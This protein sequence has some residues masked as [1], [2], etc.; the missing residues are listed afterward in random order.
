MSVLAGPISTLKKV[1]DNAP[2]RAL[3][4][5]L[6]I[7]FNSNNNIIPLH[8]QTA[9]GIAKRGGLLN[10]YVSNNSRLLLLYIRRWEF[11][12][13]IAFKTARTLDSAEIKAV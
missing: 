1:K 4:L 6:K 11:T 13:A 12:R 5:F 7:Y 2:C 9:I 3:S 10:A 8:L